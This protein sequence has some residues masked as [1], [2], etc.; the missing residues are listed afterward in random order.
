MRTTLLGLV[1]VLMASP[2]AAQE[3]ADQDGRYLVQFRDFRGA[4]AVVRAAGGTPVVELAPQSAIAAYL[5][6]QAVSGLRRNPN[7]ILVEADPRRYPM[8][9]T[10]PYGISMVQA[11][12]VSDA[13]A[14]NTTI[15][16]IDSGYYR[17]HEDLTGNTVV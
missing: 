1:V 11:D 10:T 3:A 15:C 12:Q 13:N 9:Q 16:I 4:A 7:V 2:L 8:A 6:A 17:A 14:G 5:P